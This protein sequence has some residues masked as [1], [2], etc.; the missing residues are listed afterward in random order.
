MSTLS[1]LTAG[2]R[3]TSAS[4]GTLPTV[5]HVAGVFLALRPTGVAD[6]GAEL[7]QVGGMGAAAGHE[8]NRRVADLGAVA[9]EP[10]T[11]H[12]HHNILFAEAGF[13][14]GVA[15][16]GAIQAGFDTILVLLGS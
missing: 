12:H 14:A 15:A 8:R 16:N 2:F 6:V 11:I 10:D 1:H 9:V 4:F 3:A 7:A 5:V 13:G